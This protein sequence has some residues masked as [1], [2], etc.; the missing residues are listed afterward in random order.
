MFA[1]EAGDLRLAKVATAEQGGAMTGRLEVFTGSGWGTV[2]GTPAAG[3]AAAADVTSGTEDSAGGT[4]TAAAASV[5]CRQLGFADGIR[6]QS[7]VCPT[8]P[9]H[10]AQ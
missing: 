1:A 4:F 6:I 5:A 10:K 8:P 2:C 7:T 3:D 9:P